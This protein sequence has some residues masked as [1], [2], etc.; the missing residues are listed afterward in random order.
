MLLTLSPSFDMSDREEV[1]TICRWINKGDRRQLHVIC[2]F[3]AVHL[4]SALFLP[5]MATIFS[6]ADHLDIRYWLRKLSFNRVC[7][8]IGSSP[9]VLEQF[10]LLS[11]K[12]GKHLEL[13]GKH[14]ELHHTAAAFFFVHTEYCNVK[15]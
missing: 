13:S 14:L 1:A 11:Y 9:R 8:Y 4:V 5:N 3:L 15:L 6:A 2:C 10:G 7:M 12:S